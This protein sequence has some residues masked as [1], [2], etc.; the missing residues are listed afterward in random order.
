MLGPGHDP[1]TAP[2]TSRLKAMAS[3]VKLRPPSLPDAL[4]RPGTTGASTH[5]VGVR[6]AVARIEKAH[7]P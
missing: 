4:S 2:Q 3:G 5:F 6:A 1:G 7:S